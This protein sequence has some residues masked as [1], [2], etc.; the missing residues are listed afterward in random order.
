MPATSGL[1]LAG[2]RAWRHFVRHYP[3][4]YPEPETLYWCVRN[5]LKVGEISVRMN[6]RQGGVSSI[7]LWQSVYYMLKV[8]LAIL[9]DRLRW[10][11]N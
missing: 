11:G 1:R 5:G 7:R 6:A 3:E 8:T 2:P 9:L 4:D 10:K